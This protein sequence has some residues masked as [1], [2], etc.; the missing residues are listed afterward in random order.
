LLPED[1]NW[2]LAT[3]SELAFS[4][5]LLLGL[6]TRFAAISLVVVTMVATAAVHWPADWSG[7]AGLWEGYAITS[8]GAGNFKLP[9]LFL[10]MLLPLVFHGGGRLSLD[11]L[12]LRLGNRP[13]HPEPA[14]DGLALALALFVPGLALVWVEPA[15]GAALLAAAAVAPLAALRAAR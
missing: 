7:L 5:F 13:R 12:L 3:W 10:V 15:W 11:Q 6:F 9:L 2:L 4:L 14:S 1:L 8:T